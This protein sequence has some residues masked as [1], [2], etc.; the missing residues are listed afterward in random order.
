MCL[1][2]GDLSTFTIALSVS[3]GVLR[4][5]A[6]LFLIVAHELLA[7]IANMCG[8]VLG[9]PAISALTHALL[10]VDKSFKDFVGKLGL[11]IAM[12]KYDHFTGSESR[13]SC[14]IL[15]AMSRSSVTGKLG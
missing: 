7:N 12:N 5:R 3:I 14:L 10:C 1:T 13:A 15:L 6:T 4:F 8:G 2:I 9:C 11:I